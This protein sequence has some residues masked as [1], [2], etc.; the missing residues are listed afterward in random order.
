MSNF[1][2]D[3]KFGFGEEIRATFVRF[4]KL[5]QFK[6]S[7]K[8]RMNLVV[9]FDK[10]SYFF[11]ITPQLLHGVLRNKQDCCV[12]VAATSPLLCSGL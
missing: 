6:R 8:I 11:D 2:L 4:R 3:K 10:I 12:C 9:F 5:V 1:E 7:T